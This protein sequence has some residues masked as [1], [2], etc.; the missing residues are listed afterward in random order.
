M[1]LR[2]ATSQ[3][4]RRFKTQDQ[5]PEPLCKA[6]L[7]QLGVQHVALILKVVLC[8]VSASEAFRFYPA[9]L[10]DWLSSHSIRCLMCPLPCPRFIEKHYFLF[11]LQ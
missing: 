1:K 2:E 10:V 8:L 11:I 6:L 9:S 3:G 7:Y 5:P 4:S